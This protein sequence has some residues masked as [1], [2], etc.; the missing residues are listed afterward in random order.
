MNIGFINDGYPEERMIINKISKNNCMY[1]KVHK[2][3]GVKRLIIKIIGSILKALKN[4]NYYKQIVLFDFSPIFFDK[5]DVFHLFNIVYRGK[6]NWVCTF[7]SMYP[8]TIFVHKKT[9]YIKKRSKYL[10]NRNCIGLLPMSQWSYDCTMDLLKKSV[11][12]RELC[13]IE[14]KM[15]VMS[16]PQSINISEN[17]L[18]LKYSCKDCINFT[19][20]GRE[21]W[22]KGGYISLVVLSKFSKKYNIHLNIISDLETNSEKYNPTYEEIEEIKDFI[23]NNKSWISWYK[24]LKNNKVMELLKETHIGLLPTYR[25]TYGFSVLE[26]QASGCPVITTNINA[27]SEINNESRGWIIDMKKYKKGQDNN[28]FDDNVCNELF[29]LIESQLN[30]ILKDIFGNPKS[31]KKKGMAA[32]EYIKECH[33]PEKYAEELYKIYNTKLGGVK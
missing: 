7:E 15:Q 33:S 26:M 32:I 2:V 17:E 13:I 27:L 10:L 9:N 6:K 11:T 20:I 4:T 28:Y 24:N 31:I 25:D 12:K 16:P 21:F 19:F 8:V 3:S 29:D 18:K 14:N 23:N 22:R 1:K 30:Q 5:A